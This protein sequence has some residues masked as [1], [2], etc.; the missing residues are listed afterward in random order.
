M[1][2]PLILNKEI[3]KYDNN[4][5][6]IFKHHKCFKCKKANILFILFYLNILYKNIIYHLCL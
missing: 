4:M 5:N 2:E 3:T 6:F 1:K